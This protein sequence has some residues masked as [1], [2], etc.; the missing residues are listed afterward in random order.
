MDFAL[1]PALVELRERARRYTVDAL[2]PLEAQFE[3]D[4][5]VLPRATGNELRKAAIEANL[6]AGSLPTAVGGQGWTVMEQVIVH[7]QLGQV[8]GGLW[9][10]IP[11]AYNVL[12]H[13]DTAQRKR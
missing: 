8:T 1:T 7:E 3:R 6:H 9:S 5:G 12:L 4:H 2:Q 13:A 11:G 10:Y